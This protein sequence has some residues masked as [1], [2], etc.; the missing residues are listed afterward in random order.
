MIKINSKAKIGGYNLTQKLSWFIMSAFVS[1]KAMHVKT[2]PVG[3][4]G[5]VPGLLSGNIHGAPWKVRYYKNYFDFH[6]SDYIPYR[7]FCT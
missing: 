1:Q 6:K 7:T 5:F 4:A 3:Y 2:I